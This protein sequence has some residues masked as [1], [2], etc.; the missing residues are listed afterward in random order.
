MMFVGLP[1]RPL[2][3]GERGPEARHAPLA[4]DGGDERR[5]LAADEGAR[6]FLYL[7]I[8]A[9]RGAEDVL[10]EVAFRKELP[11]GQLQPLDRLR[12]LGP[13]VDV[14]FLRAD[15]VCAD[16]H[17]FEHRVGVSLQGAA[18]H[19]RAGVALVGIADDVFIIAGGLPAEAPF[20]PGQEAS[21]APAP[22]AGSRNRLYH[23][24]RCVILQYLLDGLIAA[25]RDV[26]LNRVGVYDPAVPQDYP[27]LL[28]EEKI[29]VGGR[30][31]L[32]DPF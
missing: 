25:R 16:H 21:A 5:L 10:A 3:G 26:F 11:Y 29:V 7:Y 15:G 12:V 24:F 8:E 30:F 19:E 23:L 6:S 32:H 4:L 28:L 18:V 1:Q 27:L 9:H 14:A 20:H 17:A 2:F 22:E 31:P 13:H